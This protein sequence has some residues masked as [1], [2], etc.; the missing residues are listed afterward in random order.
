MTKPISVQLYSLRELAK[1]DFVSVLKKV[2]DIGYV[3][4]EPAGLWDLQPKEFLK[5]IEDLGLK[6]FSSHTPWA[7]I[8]N[9]DETMETASALGLKKIVCGY[10]ADDFKDMDSIKKTAENTCIMQEKL[11]QNGFT[12]FQHNHDFEFQRLDGRIK[13]EIYRELCPKVKYQMDCFWS[14]GLGKEDPVEMLKLFKD[15]IVS[16]HMKDGFSEQKVSGNDMVN[17]ILERKVDLMPLGTGTLPIKDLVKEI[18]E[19]VDTIIVELD[20]CNID[21]L[22]AIEQSYKY[23]TE[24][25]LA[26]GNK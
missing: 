25:G 8:N 20:F 5:I 9:L 6:M 19:A 2:A 10:G 14:T 15:D 16:I 22:T 26:K 23:M 13:Y 1:Q 11:A 3:G 24:N 7:R 4:V 18:P 17:G 21:M 12:L